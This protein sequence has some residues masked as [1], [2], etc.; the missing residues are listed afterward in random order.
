MDLVESHEKI[1]K[2]L[3]A[4]KEGGERSWAQIGLLLDE[5]EQTLFWQMERAD[6]FTVWIK[7]YHHFHLK[8]A[9]LWRYLTAV[10]YYKTLHQDLS[11][12]GVSSPYPE[13][14]PDKVS[15]ESIELL[16]KLVR[17][18]PDDVFLSLAKQVLSGAIA[19]AKL[20]QTWEVYRPI[21]SGRTARGTS[22]PPMINR[23]DP[24]Q[25]NLA[26]EAE[27][28]SALF[29]TDPEWT[30]YS[31]PDFYQLFTNVAPE[32]GYNTVSRFTFDVVAVVRMTPGSPLE[33]HGIEVQG[34]GGRIPDESLWL[35]RQ[36]YCDH[37]WLAIHQQTIGLDV[38]NLPSYVGL[39][40][41]DERGF[42]IKRWGEG[43]PKLGE[44]NGE[45]AKALLLKALHR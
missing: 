42:K 28:L 25:Q 24:K 27:I 4:L 32:V 33:F 38:Q 20:R 11:R 14:L 9:S 37:L 45:L 36:P 39:M 7:S 12:R 16:S 17:V 22:M 1:S 13:E 29:N 10:R 44:R 2:E 43:S 35:Q 21:L 15:P 5:V 30:T 26:R 3:Q 19:R 6:S 8:E 18:A 40:V 31:P 23:D 41:A 34:E